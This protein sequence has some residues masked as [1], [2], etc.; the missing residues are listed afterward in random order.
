MPTEVCSIVLRCIFHNALPFNCLI[1]FVGFF[2]C[3][4]KAQKIKTENFLFHRRACE[5]I[6]EKN[7]HF[8]CITQCIMQAMQWPV[9]C[10]VLLF[11]R[12]QRKKS[13]WK[14]KVVLVFWLH[15]NIGHSHAQSHKY[16]CLNSMERWSNTFFG[17]QKCTKL[18]TFARIDTF[19]VISLLFLRDSLNQ[20]HFP[21]LNW[22][23]L[24]DKRVEFKTA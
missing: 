6:C 1:K 2:K 19:L 13:V 17:N 18:N 23:W 24:T 12:N 14:L 16:A 8:A 20:M 21:R 5:S 15:T 3:N 11:K 4:K 10:F 7:F 22:K 9:N